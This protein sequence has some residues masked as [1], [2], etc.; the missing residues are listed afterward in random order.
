MQRKFAFLAALAIAVAALRTLWHRRVPRSPVV[1]PALDP[2]AE[3]L[4]R[5]LAASRE[6]R[7]EPE[8]PA[9]EVAVLPPA[10]IQRDA[11]ADVEPAGVEIDEARRRVH[12]EARQAID[13][14]RR[15]G[16]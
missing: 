5:R 14:M 4:R 8:D 11:T 1:E 10:A 9:P 13:E 2:R 7:A 16:D 12:E 6:A 3:E 15:S